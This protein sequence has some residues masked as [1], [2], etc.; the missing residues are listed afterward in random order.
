MKFILDPK[1]FNYGEIKMKTP[2]NFKSVKMLA[3]CLTRFVMCLTND[4]G[5]FICTRY[6]T[7]TKYRKYTAVDIAKGRL[8]P[9]LRG[10]W[11][12]SFD[13]QGGFGFAINWAGVRVRI[14]DR[15][16]GYPAKQARRPTY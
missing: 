16:K 11:L 8:L 10:T 1:I 12:P 3:I 14:S 13:H 9:Y 15:G 7:I 4:H 6:L 2:L 5:N